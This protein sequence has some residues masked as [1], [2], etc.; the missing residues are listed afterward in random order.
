[1]THGD[2]RDARQVILET[3]RAMVSG[4]LDLVSGARR[5]CDLRYEIAATESELFFPIIGFE[6]E[7][8]DY[9]VGDVRQRFGQEYLRKLDEEIS[10]YI[11]EARP[12][13]IAACE[14]IIEAL[15]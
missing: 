9:P 5:L 14:K 2:V 3:A 12:V 13:V 10:P 8:D 15:S 7:V 4:E 11:E 6:S 1:M